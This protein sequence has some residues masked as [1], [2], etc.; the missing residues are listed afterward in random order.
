[1]RID[2]KLIIDLWEATDAIRGGSANIF[3]EKGKRYELEA[4]YFDEGSG[5][6]MIASW[7]LPGRKGP[8][9]EE[10]NSAK[11]REVYLPGNKP[12]YDFWT[13]RIYEGGKTIVADAPIEK[14][15]L[16]VKAGSIVPMGPFMQYANE[17]QADTLEVRIY[18]GADGQ[19]N[20][21]ED[22]GDNYN[23]EKGAYSTI[24]FKWNDQNK[25]ITVDQRKGSFPEML[26]ERV[27]R[28]VLVSESRG[29]GPS[30]SAKSNAVVKYKGEW[31]SHKFK[32]LN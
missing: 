16:F 11:M 13:G 12:W 28:F 24:Q 32:S 9:V 8:E 7:R 29:V 26:N 17:K 27:F 2:G 19:F 3:L 1:M 10:I 20:L 31:L 14:M 22:E 30:V 21:Y 4:E 5:A 15:P 6:F 23:Y 18:N 25:E